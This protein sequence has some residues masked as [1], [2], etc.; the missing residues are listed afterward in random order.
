[1]VPRVRLQLGAAVDPPG[2]RVDQGAYVRRFANGLAVVN[3]GDS[4]ITYTLPAPL[5]L[6]TPSGDGAVLDSGVVAAGWG[7]R[8]TMVSTV[9]LPPRPAAVLLP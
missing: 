8:E 1:M 9:T 5:R 4:T 2:L 7:M 3:P 6:Q